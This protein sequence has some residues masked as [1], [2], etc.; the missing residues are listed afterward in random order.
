M[1]GL[2]DTVLLGITAGSPWA[3][4]LAAACGVATA[5]GPCAAPRA[6]A[7]SA[8]TAH[9]SR[10]GAVLHA[11]AFIAGICLCYATAGYLV[12]CAG[13]AGVS[14]PLAYYATA[15]ALCVCG[16]VGLLGRERV[17]QEERSRTS[18]AGFALGA[19]SASIVSPCCTV[20]MFPIAIAASQAGNPFRAALLM[21]CFSLGHALPASIAALFLRTKRWARKSAQYL[22]ALRTVMAAVTLATGIYYGVLA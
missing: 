12:A 21:G 15:L 13:G 1:T 18:S 5:A 11:A 4:A 10:S 6:A 17:C 14:S 2:A 16:V 19:L 7:L 22:P 8:L 3:P 20:L 9:E